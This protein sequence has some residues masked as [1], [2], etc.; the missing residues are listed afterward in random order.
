MSFERINDEI[1]ERPE[2]KNCILVYGY[3]DNEFEKISS[4]TKKIGIDKIL[5][6]ESQEVTL[7]LED[8]VNEIKN[9]NDVDKGIEEKAIIFNAVSDSE[10]HNFVQEFK[11]LNLNRPLFAAVTETSKKWKFSDL[12]KELMA[13]KKAF[14]ER[15]KNKT[16]K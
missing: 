5:K 13:E 6:I 1:T 11:T 7:T 16:K 2:G 10:L 12:I 4:Y 3:N 15:R 14:E 8:L 9:N